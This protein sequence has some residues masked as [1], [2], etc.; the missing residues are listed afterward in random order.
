MQMGV[1]VAIVPRLLMAVRAAGRNQ[2]VQKLWQV[3]L[4]ARFE[5]NGADR[6]RAADVKDVRSAGV[7]SRACDNC[8]NAAGEI[9][10]VTMPTGAN[11]KLLLMNHVLIV[12]CAALAGEVESR[13]SAGPFTDD[14]QWQTRPMLL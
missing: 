11:G 12:I 1:A 2:F 3:A 7:D 6:G 4:Q 10:H 14:R 8:T 5:L 13:A 9:M